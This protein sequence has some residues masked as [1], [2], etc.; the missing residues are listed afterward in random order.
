MTSQTG[1]SN[2]YSSNKTEISFIQVKSN[3][4]YSLHS[5]TKGS[6]DMNFRFIA[7]NSNEAKLEISIAKRGH[8]KLKFSGYYFF[9]AQ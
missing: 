3:H 7:N 2:R 5:A 4:K 6:G 1:I 8:F 9:R